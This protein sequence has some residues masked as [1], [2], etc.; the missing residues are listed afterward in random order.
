[1]RSAPF[2]RA[3]PAGVLVRRV[4]SRLVAGC[5]I[6][7]AGAG[8]SAFGQSAGSAV[9]F[10]RINMA[11]E[12]VDAPNG[13]SLKQSR[14]SNNRSVL[15]V[16]GSEDL[17]DGLKAIWQIQGSVAPDT[18]TGSIA[19][20]DTRV[21]LSGGLG[22]VFAG[23][24]SLP[25]TAATSSFD[26]FYPTTAGYMALMGN[27]SAALADNVSDRTSFD[28]RQQNV[29]QYWSPEWSGLS[30]QLAYAFNEETVAATGAKPSLLSAAATYAHAPWS[31][32]LAHEVHRHYQTASGSDTGTKFGVSYDLA[33]LR[34]AAVV[35]RLKYETASGDLTR[36]A[37]Y[38]SARYKLGATTLL[39]GYSRARDGRGSAA[40]P[41]GFIGNGSHTGANQ[42]TLGAEYAFSHRTSVFAYVSRI[43][44]ASE[45][46]YDFAVNQA[47]VRRGEDPRVFALGIRHDF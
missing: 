30:A 35:E 29:V 32:T 45:A 6:S 44:N 47:A 11:L 36:I 25:Y 22:T 15:G 27:G 31:L 40:Q 1:M 12:R 7:V 28:R 18:G 10:G 2:P 38:V 13:S 4:T 8:G 5:A 43:G 24:W 46:A 23:S 3:G 42:L 33:P 20:R 34:L 21:G 16:K 39:G 19:S 17:G 9:V 37:A 14:L 41:V 26:P